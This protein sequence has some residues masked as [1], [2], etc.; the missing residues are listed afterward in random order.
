MAEQ[1]YLEAISCIER[2]HRCF[3]ELVKLELDRLG[4]RDVNNVQA[5]MLFNIADAEM[6]IGELSLRGCY[7]GRNVS[8]NVRKLVEIGYLAQSRSK[9]DRRTSHVKLTKK[10]GALRD[11]LSGMHNRHLEMLKQTALTPADLET[12]I[13][14]LRSLERCWTNSGALA[15]PAS[16]AAA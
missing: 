12:A 15:L 10:G 14:T 8:Y 6:S 2:L 3:L 9:H 11:R 7:L 5:L 13:T 16:P 4:V 1:Q